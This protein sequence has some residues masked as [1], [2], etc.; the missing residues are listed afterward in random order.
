MVGAASAPVNGCRLNGAFLWLGVRRGR[1]L[2]IGKWNGD[3]DT[4]FWAW[5]FM[6]APLPDSQAAW[7]FREIFRGKSLPEHSCFLTKRRESVA[8]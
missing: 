5:A 1:E 4:A 3:S 2:L 6:R 7:T 8:C